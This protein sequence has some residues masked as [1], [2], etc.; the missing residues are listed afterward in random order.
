M[1]SALTPSEA[2]ARRDALF[3]DVREPYEWDAG[4]ITGSLHI[5]IGQIQ[6]R[7]DELDADRDII[8]VC[9]VGQRSELVANWLI[10]NGYRAHNLTG[11]LTSWTA[12]GLPLESTESRGAVVDGWARDLE[13]RRLDGADE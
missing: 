1:S 12:A 8:V 4:H 9:Q 13:G 11:G 6:S 7:Y 10:A 5:P 2:A 3:L